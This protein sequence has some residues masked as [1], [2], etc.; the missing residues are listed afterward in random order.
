M[1][2]RK[3]QSIR[4][5]CIYCKGHNVYHNIISSQIWNWSDD[6]LSGSE[7]YEILECQGCKR[8]RIHLEEHFSESESMYQDEYGEWYVKFE[9]TFRI[10]TSIDELKNP[11]LIID[12]KRMMM[13]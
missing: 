10:Y 8:L 2:H 9:P 13:K 11:S 7:T 3:I 4:L 12:K 6:F 5:T 1:E